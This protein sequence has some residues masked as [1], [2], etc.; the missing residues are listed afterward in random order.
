MNRNF[1]LCGTKSEVMT[2]GI[3]AAV[4][5]VYWELINQKVREVIVVLPG[6]TATTAGHSSGT[7]DHCELPCDL[8]TKKANRVHAS[9]LQ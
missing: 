3:P 6:C 1:I 2:L 7:E 5:D 9:Y 8:T 4:L